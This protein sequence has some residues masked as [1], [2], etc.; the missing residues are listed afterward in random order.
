MK[1]KFNDDAYHQGMKRNII[2]NI[3]LGVLI[4]IIIGIFQLITSCT[5]DPPEPLDATDQGN[6]E[7]GGMDH[8]IDDW[9]PG[10]EGETTAKPKP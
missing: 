7:V 10:D 1:N 6:T 4:A 5:P 8:N 2:S 9:K 3:A